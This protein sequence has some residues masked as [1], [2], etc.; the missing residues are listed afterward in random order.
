MISKRIEQTCIPTNCPAY[1]LIAFVLIFSV[2]RSSAQSACPPNIGFEEG[3]FN[4]WEMSWGDT[5]PTDGKITLHSGRGVLNLIMN[6]GGTVPTDPLG[7]FPVISP[8]GSKYSLKIG[9]ERPSASADQVAYNLVVPTN[10]SGYSIIFDY[11]VVLQNPSHK[12]YEQPRF[13]VKVFNVTRG[14]YIRC[15]SYDFVAGYNQPGFIESSNSGIFYKPWSSVTLDLSAYAGETVR[16]EFTATDCALGAHFG[17]AYIDVLE[18]C[19]SPVNGNAICPGTTMTS[20]QAPPGFMDYLWY[21]GDLTQFLGKGPTYNV[22]SPNV[23]DSFAVVLVPYPYLSCYDTIQTKISFV[24]NPMSLQVNEPL[25]GCANEGFDLTRPSVTMGSSGIDTYEYFMDPGGTSHLDRPFSIPRNG[26]YYI[27][28]S[29]K[30]GC[31]IIKPA[32]VSI[33]NNPVFNISNPPEIT[34]PQ[35]LDL[36]S[37]VDD[38]NYSFS[39]WLDSNLTKSVSNPHAVQSSGEYFIEAT[40]QYGCSLAKSVVVKVHPMIM[41]PTAFTPNNDGKNDVFIYKALGGIE[42]IEYFT[43]YDR[44]GGTVFRTTKQGEGW[45]GK[46]ADRPLPSGV[47]VWILNAKDWTGEMHT[48]KGTVMLIR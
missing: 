23:G 47:Y 13:L 17:Y 32:V 35:K 41:V 4:H 3:T 18:K 45:N 14:E 27:K 8:N 24:G 44:W 46:N 29:N 26:T 11:A 34:Y 36:L 6:N 16:L 15:S 7:G 20:M 33:Y 2:V 30:V 22:V 21:T 28:A 42:S 5:S 37:V 39:Y 31:S 43:I 25:I 38:K 12:D 19:T 40:N 10:S 9:D 1:L 48:L